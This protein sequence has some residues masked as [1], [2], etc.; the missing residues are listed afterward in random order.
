[1][2]SSLIQSMFIYL[3]IYKH[4]SCTHLALL[5]MRYFAEETWHHVSPFHLVVTCHFHSYWNIIAAAVYIIMH[6]C[7]YVMSWPWP[8]ARVLC[9]HH[10]ATCTSF[11]CGSVTII[12]LPLLQYFCVRHMLWCNEVTKSRLEVFPIESCASV[13]MTGSS[14]SA[15]WF[16]NAANIW[17]WIR[18]NSTRWWDYA[19]QHCN[20]TSK[21]ILTKS[22]ISQADEFGLYCMVS[23]TFYNTWLVS[24][25]GMETWWLTGTFGFIG[26]EALLLLLAGSESARPNWGLLELPGSMSYWGKESMNMAN[27]EILIHDNL[28]FI[29]RK[30][31]EMVQKHD[32]SLVTII[33]HAYIM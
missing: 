4:S 28:F 26:A 22:S 14:S 27:K 24:N 18:V 16:Y 25:N 23:I 13:I 17:L 19:T 1:M 33:R 5:V 8:H 32:V 29:S 7:M 12:T 11:V 15:R 21:M 9:S 3:Y 31:W 6:A 20:P 10:W 2:C 30:A